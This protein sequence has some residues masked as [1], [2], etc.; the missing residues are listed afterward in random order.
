MKTNIIAYLSFNG[1]AREALEFYQSCI[2]GELAMDTIGNGPMA[3]HYPAEAH[4]QIMHGQL[5]FGELNL[6]ASDMG[7][8]DLQTGNNVGLMLYCETQEES[9]KCFEKLS[10]GGNVSHPLSEAFWGGIFGHLTDK[11]GFTWMVH[12][13]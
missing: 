7:G 4:D 8:P 11:F 9:H 2:G 13:A 6:M 12:A 1:N 10:A 3:E 5:T